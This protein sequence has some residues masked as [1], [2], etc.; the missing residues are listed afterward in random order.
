MKRQER[1]SQILYQLVWQ[2]NKQ[3]LEAN[4]NKLDNGDQNGTCLSL[5]I[6]THRKKKKFHIFLLMRTKL[7]TILWLELT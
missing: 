6:H 4:T 2:L 7:I 3:T 1:G 5:S